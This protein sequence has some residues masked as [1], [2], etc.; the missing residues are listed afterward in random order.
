M[1]HIQLLPAFGE[2][3]RFH[4]FSWSGM[5]QYSLAYSS[6]PDRSSVYGQGPQAV[7]TNREIGSLKDTQADL[8]LRTSVQLF[9]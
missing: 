4:R 5:L 8:N 9:F 2:H 1:L 3:R 6:G 7:I